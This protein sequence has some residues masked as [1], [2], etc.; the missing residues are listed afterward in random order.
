M[1]EYA[2]ILEAERAESVH[3]RARQRRQRARG[4]RRQRNGEEE[5]GKMGLCYF[6]YLNG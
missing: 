6:T 2:L 5:K 3:R 1:R 4:R